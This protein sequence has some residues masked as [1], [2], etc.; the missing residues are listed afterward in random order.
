MSAE[1]AGVRPALL[2]SPLYEALTELKGFRHRV[3]HRYGF[4]LRAYKVHENLVRVRASLPS[5]I[6]AVSAMES[7]LIDEEH[8]ES[9]D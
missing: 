6:D 2:T 5:F 3:R 7:V 9:G 1:I 8:G 4:D